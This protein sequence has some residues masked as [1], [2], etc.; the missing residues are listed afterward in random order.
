MKKLGSDKNIVIQQSIWDEAKRRTEQTYSTS[1]L[2]PYMRC[3]W[4]VYEQTHRTF[5]RT[6]L[7]QFLLESNIEDFA[8]INE[9]TVYV[10]T[11]HK[12][13]GREFDTIHLWLMG[14]KKTEADILR[15]I[16]V[17]LTRA[18][19]NLYIHT[20]N[21]LFGQKQTNSTPCQDSHIIVTLSMRDVWLDNFREHKSS[22]LALR[23]GDEINYKDGLLITKRGDYLGSLSQGMFKKINQ[24]SKKG[25][26]VV[27][28]E[29]SYVLAWRP[30]DKK[31]EVAVCLANLHLSLVHGPHTCDA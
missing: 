22:V 1:R 6:D 21:P 2:L 25:Y 29:V 3:F 18:R 30:R 7:R 19:H 20:N 13:K 16:Y 14:L 15:T 31:E 28:A 5:Y 10:S 9:T 8:N 24:L 17:G 4:T 23:S 26:Q 27:H 12:A 11:I